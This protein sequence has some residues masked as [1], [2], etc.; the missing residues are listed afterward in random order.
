MRLASSAIPARRAS[1][2]V[3]VSLMHERC[4][5]AFAKISRA[6]SRLL[7][8]YRRL[9]TFMPSRVHFSTL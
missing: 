4:L 9:S 2:A 1:A 8:A 6:L 3:I 7:P 5:I